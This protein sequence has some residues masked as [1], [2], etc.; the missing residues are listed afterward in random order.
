M[1][2]N[3]AFVLF[4]LLITPHGLLGSED[5]PVPTST[6]PAQDAER[7]Q[8]WESPDMVEARLYMED[9]F[10][11]A[12][13]ATEAEADEF[14]NSLDGMTTAELKDWLSR[15][16]HQ[17]RQRGRLLESSDQ[18]RGY[19]LAEARV[20]RSRDEQ[21]NAQFN[22]LVRQGANLAQSRVEKGFARTSKQ[23]RYPWYP[24]RNRLFL[25]YRF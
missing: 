17:R 5:I 23:K 15:F 25:W 24:R 14:W 8:F 4:A 13:Q 3:L 9:Y 19:K 11:T 7:Q 2:R 6:M 18:I 21:I 16:A 10:A 20:A 22:R 12:A 1:I